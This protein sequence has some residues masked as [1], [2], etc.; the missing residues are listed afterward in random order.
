MPGEFY[1]EGKNEKI[2]L[3]EI[4]NYITEVYEEITQIQNNVTTIVN[5]QGQQY[6]FLDF[7]SE[8][9]EGVTIQ[10][11][12]TDVALPS[13]IVS[14]LPAG[15]AV[16]RAIVI[17]KFRILENTNSNE[18]RINGDQ[19]IQVRKSGGIWRDAISILD[20]TFTIAGSARENGDVCIGDHNIS[21]AIYG[22]GTY[23]F[24][25]TLSQV[26]KNYLN[27]NDIQTGLRIM[28]SL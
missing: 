13:V 16:I 20:D 23:E 14:G 10:D 5:N 2:D 25:W 8:P 18:N 3:T 4:K 12:V 1:I 11:G 28:Y 19:H 9:R 26:S 7:W 24:Q 6:F 27:F 17:F 15:A 22:D 21:G